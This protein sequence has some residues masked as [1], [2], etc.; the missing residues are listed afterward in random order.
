ML[1]RNSPTRYTSFTEEE[2]AALQALR[3]RHAEPQPF[4]ERELAHLRFVRWLV[5]RPGWSRTPREPGYSDAVED[6]V[7]DEPAMDAWM[8]DLQAAHDAGYYRTEAAEGRQTV[9]PWANKTCKDCPFW[10]SGICD[11]RAEYRWPSAHTCRY[12]DPWNRSTAQ[13]L[14]EARRWQGFRRWWEWFNDRGATG[15]AT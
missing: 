6:E 11:V 10:S 12:F 2:F 14:I 7:V 4:T 5:S 9:F 1:D 15:H 13:T 3:A 8:D